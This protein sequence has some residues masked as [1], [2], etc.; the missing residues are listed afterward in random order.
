VNA[1]SNYENNDSVYLM[2][3]H[4]RS[5][6]EGADFREIEDLVSNGYTDSSG[7]AIRSCE[8]SIRQ[9]VQGKVGVWSNHNDAFGR[10]VGLMDLEKNEVS[11]NVNKL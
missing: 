10:H 11:S 8:D 1:T 2:F 7:F 4:Q 3:S 5:V 6:K 9:I